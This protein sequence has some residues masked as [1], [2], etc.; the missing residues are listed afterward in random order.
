M[1][2]R[3]KARGKVPCSANVLQE[4]LFLPCF[5]LKLCPG[6]GKLPVVHKVHAH[7]TGP[8]VL[9]CSAAGAGLACLKTSPVLF[10]ALDGCLEAQVFFKSLH[11]CLR[12]FARSRFLRKNGGKLPFPCLAG[13]KLILGFA[14]GL[15][16]GKVLAKTFPDPGQC[17]DKFPKAPLGL[18]KLLQVFSPCKAGQKI[19]TC[20]LALKGKALTLALR[21]CHHCLKLGKLLLPFCPF[22]PE[23]GQGILFVGKGFCLGLKG[24]EALVNGPDVACKTCVVC[25][26][27]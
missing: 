11:V 2:I 10:K 26:I 12:L 25:G 7:T 18:A 16:G 3:L 5:L 13:L 4:F 21:P 14:K 22:L 24:I 6:S 15:C 8:G 1:H 23:L 20:L 19:C 17:Q 27:F 9:K